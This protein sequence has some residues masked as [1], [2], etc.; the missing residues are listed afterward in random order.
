[1]L[2]RPSDP[3][4]A[5]PSSRASWYAFAGR[6]LS[7]RLTTQRLGSCTRFQPSRARR[8]GFQPPSPALVPGHQTPRPR[9]VG[10]PTGPSAPAWR[11]DAKRKGQLS[12]A[13]VSLVATYDSYPPIVTA[14]PQRRGVAWSKERRGR[15]RAEK[16]LPSSTMLCAAVLEVKPKRRANPGECHAVTHALSRGARYYAQ[17]PRSTHGP[18]SRRPKNKSRHSRRQRGVGVLNVARLRRPGA[19]RKRRPGSGAGVKERRVRH[20]ARPKKSTAEAAP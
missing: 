19:N 6:R 10:R 9:L 15:S 1:M 11:R 7:T 14:K 2:A 12:L 8:L 20:R 3:T 4:K 13:E 18:P 5:A 16:N 17:P